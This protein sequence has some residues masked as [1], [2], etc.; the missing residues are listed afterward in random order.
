MAI[1]THQAALL[2][3]VEQGVNYTMA[4]LNVNGDRPFTYS[5]MVSQLFKPMPTQ[6]D[7]FMHAA[8]GIVG[9]RRELQDATNRINLGE[10][11]GDAEFYIEALLQTIPE[12][13]HAVRV[14]CTEDYCLSLFAG[15]TP[16]KAVEIID[17]AS[18]EILN[19][20][21]KNWVYQKPLGPLEIE[22]IAAWLME[23]FAALDF[24]YDIYDFDAIAVL[25]SNAYKLVGPSGRFKDFA[26]SDAAAQNRADKAAGE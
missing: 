11:F 3:R 25:G 10:E 5:N 13:N 19:M 17:I 9:E 23:I 20:A 6:A 26:Y 14:Q 24:L 1:T 22:S 18:I 2:R 4:F 15:L 7:R 16:Q 12:L 8:V 21:K